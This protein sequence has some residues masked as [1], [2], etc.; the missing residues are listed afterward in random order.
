MHN[1]GKKDMQ[2]R[3]ELESLVEQAEA[4]QAWQLDSL[5]QSSCSALQKTWAVLRDNDHEVPLAQQW[6]S[7]RCGR[8]S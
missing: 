8:R 3:E 6:C 7:L 4:A 1:C 5:K 2:L